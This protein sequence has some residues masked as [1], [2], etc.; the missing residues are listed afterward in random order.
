MA[1]PVFFLDEDEGPRYALA[2]ATAVDNEPLLFEYLPQLIEFRNSV[3]HNDRG[4]I[5]DH[6]KNPS[7]LVERLW[8]VLRAIHDICCDGSPFGEAAEVA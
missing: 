4:A 6:L 7:V 8:W 3:F 2:I 5:P 1:T